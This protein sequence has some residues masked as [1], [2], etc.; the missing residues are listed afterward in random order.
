M[1]RNRNLPS[2]PL[3]RLLL[4][5]AL[6][7]TSNACA[8]FEGCERHV[9]VGIPGN[10]GTPLCRLGYALAH[11][12]DTKTPYWVA[13]YLP[14]S[15]AMAQGERSNRFK[16]D[17]DLPR[18]ERAETSD[19]AKSGFDQGHMAPSADM[20]WSEEANIQSFY[21]SN[22]APQVGIGMNRGIWKELEADARLW[23]IRRGK[24]YIFTGPI[25]AN[26][27]IRR[28]GKNKVGVPTHFYK[29]V[30]DPDEEEAIA[31]IMPNQKLQTKDTPKFIVSVREV[32]D[33]TGLRFFMALD[34]STRRKLRDMVP[35]EPWATSVRQER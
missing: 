33:Q 3:K 35:E 2:P 13:E 25:Y 12:S 5:V 10:D 30:Y 29:I 18:G 34:A 11:N 19:Y 28:I 24:V 17:P 16:A 15:R 6:L 1:L 14:R 21:L 26:E 27:R 4:L 23:A 22:M 7:F 8:Q 20:N 9:E 32:E 31:F